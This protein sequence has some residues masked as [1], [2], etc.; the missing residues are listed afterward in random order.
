MKKSGLL[1]LVLLLSL[2]SFATEA[3]SRV[4]SGLVEMAEYII[5]LILLL[6]GATAVLI[7]SVLNIFLRHKVIAIITYILTLISLL[8]TWSEGSEKL[9]NRDI[10]GPLSIMYFSLFILS[11]AS[12]LVLFWFD[13]IPL[14][15][16][17]WRKA[18]KISEGK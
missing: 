12:L 14:L 9:L 15:Q 11:L 16:K 7:F 17:V 10:S 5:I 6:A 13:G 1:L 3:S 4:G 8:G 2:P 18:W